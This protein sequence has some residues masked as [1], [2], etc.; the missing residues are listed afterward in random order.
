MSTSGTYR[1]ARSVPEVRLILMHVKAI[2][3][4]AARDANLPPLG[5][6]QAILDGARWGLAWWLLGR[7]A[8]RC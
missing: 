4:W 6:N 1:A 3:M 5:T 7:G 2:T 8:A